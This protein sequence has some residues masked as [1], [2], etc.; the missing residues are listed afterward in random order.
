MFA[1]STISDFCLLVDD[2]DGMISFYRD[3]LGFTPR[4]RAQ[5]FAD[6][7]T[8]GVTLALWQRSHMVEH[9]GVPSHTPQPAGRSSMSAIEVA[10][11][12]EVDALAA[13]LTGRGVSLLKTAAWY[14]WNAYAFYFED[15]ERH[16]WEIYAWGDGGH[17]GLLP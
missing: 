12:A 7:A 6:F 3:T 16:L 17:T 13:D 15:P 8:A 4:R 1:A 9:V 11:P 5:G 14:P 2:L 10:S